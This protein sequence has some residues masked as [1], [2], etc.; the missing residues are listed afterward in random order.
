MHIDIERKVMK[1]IMETVSFSRIIDRNF[2]IIK[3]EQRLYWVI[4]MSTY[5]KPTL[6]RSMKRKFK[7]VDATS[8]AEVPTQPYD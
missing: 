7:L 3:T 4:Q 8:T 2:K 6:N 5:Y 1:K